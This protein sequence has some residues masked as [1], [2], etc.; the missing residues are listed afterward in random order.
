MGLPLPNLST[1]RFHQIW[2]RY[3]SRSEPGMINALVRDHQMERTE[4]LKLV[5]SWIQE[6]WIVPT[7]TKDNHFEIN[8]KLN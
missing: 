5:Q 1:E 8:K 6:H 2:K 7:E 4:A 3:R